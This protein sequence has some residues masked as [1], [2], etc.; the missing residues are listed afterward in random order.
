[1][2][3]AASAVTLCTTGNSATHESMCEAIEQ[4]RISGHRG[5]QDV[6]G[7]MADERLPSLPAPR[8]PSSHRVGPDRAGSEL[9]ASRRQ[10]L[11]EPAWL[12]DL[13]SPLSET[14]VAG[15]PRVVAFP[16]L[17][18][19]R[20]GPIRAYGSSG[21]GFAAHRY[22][23]W[24]TRGLENGN[25][26]RISTIRSQ[27]KGRLERPASAACA[28]RL[29]SG[30]RSARAGGRCS[31]IVADAAAARQHGRREDRLAR[32]AQDG[33]LSHGCILHLNPMLDSSAALAEALDLLPASLRRRL[34]RVAGLRR[35]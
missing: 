29:A 4:V 30:A 8:F 20:T 33:R 23:E 11:P 14:A 10:P 2:P 25:A 16:G 34:W 7:M 12:G 35:P 21:H 31:S 26:F 18:Q 17:P 3:S 1:M 28:A 5:R 9:V 27:Y 13:P 22:T 32:V 15:W 24:T 6:A 19:I